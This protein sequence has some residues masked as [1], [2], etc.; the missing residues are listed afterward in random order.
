MVFVI[1][2]RGPPS[3][4]PPY[5][6][7]N[8]LLYVAHVAV[9]FTATSVTCYF[10][11]FNHGLRNLSLC[12]KS[13][14]GKAQVPWDDPLLCVSLLTVALVISLVGVFPGLSPTVLFHW[15]HCRF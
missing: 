11:S 8:C 3:V 5:L 2:F 7:Q 10:V 4:P 9:T 13:D 1:S 12:R 14:T 6:C 15:F